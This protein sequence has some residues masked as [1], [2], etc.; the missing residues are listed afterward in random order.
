MVTG[1]EKDIRKVT[2]EDSCNQG[3]FIILIDEIK[4]SL[5]MATKYIHERQTQD[6]GHF[7]AR[8]PPGNLRD[9]FFDVN[10]LHVLGRQPNPA[11]L[12]DYFYFDGR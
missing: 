12:R 4:D 3:G 5:K 6:G 11:G 10:S 8:I 7:F 9:T 1:V 2:S